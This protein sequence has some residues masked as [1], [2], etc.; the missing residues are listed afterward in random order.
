[1]NKNNAA[2]R[3][4]KRKKHFSKPLGHTPF[5]AALVELRAAETKTETKS[6]GAVRVSHVPHRAAGFDSTDLGR[7][8]AAVEYVQ[9]VWLD[10]MEVIDASDFEDAADAVGYT[11]YARELVR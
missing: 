10:A 1:M 4:A 11:A 6:L 5:V 7:S 8:I 9:G 3:D 2:N